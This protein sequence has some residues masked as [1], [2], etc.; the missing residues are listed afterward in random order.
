VGACRAFGLARSAYDIIAARTSDTQQDFERRITPQRRAGQ[1]YRGTAGTAKA[2]E[3][4][5]VADLPGWP[6]PWTGQEIHE[7]CANVTAAT[8]RL[9]KRRAVHR[10]TGPTS[11]SYRSNGSGLVAIC[12]LIKHAWRWRSGA[13]RW[14]GSG[15]GGAAWPGPRRCNQASRFSAVVRIV[16]G[17]CSCEHGGLKRPT[18]SSASAGLQSWSDSTTIQSTKFRVK[19]L[20]CESKNR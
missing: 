11:V 16:V 12:R 10:A 9:A 15:A 4:D 7:T 18:S 2:S 17:L 3:V 5:R 8:L 14:R 19:V 1:V 13:D 20:S 6:P